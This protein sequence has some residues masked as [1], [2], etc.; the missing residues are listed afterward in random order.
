[1]SEKKTPSRKQLTH[2][3]KTIIALLHTEGNSIRDIS[4]KIGAAR[5][6]VRRVVSRFRAGKALDRVP[7]TGKARKLTDTERRDIV[8]FAKR[9]PTITARELRSEVGREDVCINTILRPI[10]EDGELDSYWQT[11]KPF[12]SKK[13]QVK[14]LKWCQEHA[15]WTSN[16]WNRVLWSDESPFVLRYNGRQRV[17]RRH[18]E[19]YS[20]KALKGSF[21]QDSKINVWGCF[22]AHGVGR[23][24]R[25][26]GIMDSKVYIKILDNDLKDS[27]KALFKKKPYI[28]QQDNDPKHKS[29][30]T[31]EYLEDCGIT[32][33]DWPAQSPDL[34]P[35][36]N[37]WSILDKRCKNRKPESVE[38]LFQDLQKAWE[39]LPGDLLQKLVDSM[40]ARISAVINAKGLP[41][42]F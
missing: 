24:H 7:G 41:T 16:E 38:I 34:N 4:K 22:C 8:L 5:E 15:N 26:V 2:D 17:W 35:I 9:C 18:N 39:E 1:M 42:H 6:T 40:P 13:N 32:V 31:M 19:R 25:I 33:M 36:E 12:I 27:V 11:K 37:L 10:H 30:Q 21:K 3:K 20:V 23:L 28:F 29:K 14:R